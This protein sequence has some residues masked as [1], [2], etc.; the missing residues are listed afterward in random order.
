MQAAIGKLLF[1]A[2]RVGFRVINLV[3]SNDDARIGSFGVVLPLDLYEAIF[4]PNEPPTGPNQ[5]W[6][7]RQAV[8]L[9]AAIYGRDHSRVGVELSELSVVLEDEGKLAAAD[10]AIRDS[11][12][13]KFAADAA[14]KTATIDVSVR[15]RVVTLQG[16]APTA[17]A[18]QSA[19]TIA[20]QTAGVTQVVDR[21]SVRPKG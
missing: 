3:N 11:L 2:V 7:S 8:A 21:I 20:K 16:T 4:P 13:S 1:D 15:D 18:K 6:L 19:L 14:A 10:S 5:E 9:S 17:A 12:T